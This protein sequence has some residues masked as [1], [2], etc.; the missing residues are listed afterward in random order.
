MNCRD[1]AALLLLAVAG[2]ANAQVI[3]TATDQPSET[4]L[5]LKNGSEVRG[6]LIEIRDGFYNIE[7]K[8]GRSA[9]FAL[10]EVERM[11]RLP[12]VT[13]TTPTPLVKATP[14]PQPCGIFVTEGD[15]DRSLYAL[16]TKKPEVK[17]SKKWY[18]SNDEMYHEL[19]EELKRRGADGAYG[20]HTWQAPSG[21]SWSAPHIAGQAFT[22]T[23]AGKAALPGLK[24]RCF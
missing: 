9:K 4:L 22:W 20:V 6:T 7:L 11:E 17:L 14:T 24:G 15:L 19:A 8:G 18:G 23:E 13:Q 21:F 12:D 16:L 1:V 3:V 5:V 2:S 10:D